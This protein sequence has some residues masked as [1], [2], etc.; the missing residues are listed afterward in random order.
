MRH[1]ILEPKRRW[2]DGVRPWQR[3]VNMVAQKVAAQRQTAS[4]SGDWLAL[5]TWEDDGG[6]T[7]DSR[8][9]VAATG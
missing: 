4:L 7:V 8:Q 2:L 1:S 9:M 3:A 5:R 6:E